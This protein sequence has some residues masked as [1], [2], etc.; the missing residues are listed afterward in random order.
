MTDQN[1]IPKLRLDFMLDTGTQ[2]SFQ[3]LCFDKISHKDAQSDKIACFK[4]FIDQGDAFP[5]FQEIFK[6][7]RKIQNTCDCYDDIEQIR[8]ICAKGGTAWQEVNAKDLADKGRFIR[9]R[10]GQYTLVNIHG[11]KLVIDGIWFAIETNTGSNQRGVII[12]HKDASRLTKDEIDKALENCDKPTPNVYLQLTPRAQPY[13]A[14]FSC[15][16]EVK[17]ED[18]SGTGE[19]CKLPFDLEIIVKEDNGIPIN[20]DLILDLGN[21]RTVALKLEHGDTGRLAD[22]NAFSAN[23][24]PLTLKN[25]LTYCYQDGARPKDDC[26][27]SSSIVLQAPPFEN[28]TAGL[29]GNASS[30]PLYLQEW[31]FSEKQK[32]LGDFLASVPNIFNDTQSKPQLQVNHRITRL[33]QMFVKLSPVLFGQD[34]EDAFNNASQFRAAQARFF[35]SSP[36]RYYWDLDPNSCGT[37]W[38]MLPNEW[39]SAS[40]LGKVPTLQCELLR[41][42][43]LNGDILDNIDVDPQHP[44]SMPVSNPKRPRYPRASSLTWMLLAL[45]ERAWEQINLNTK[46]YRQKV[47][48]NVIITFPSGWLPREKDMYRKR[49]Q[50]AVNIFAKNNFDSDTRKNINLNLEFDEA[51][52]SQMPFV[53]T[54]L[55]QSPNVGLWFDLI[56]RSRNGKNSV[57][58]MNLD[59][60]G[61]TTDYSIIKYSP[62]GRRTAGIA[63]NVDLIYKDGIA[64]AGDDLLRGIIDQ[65]ILRTISNAKLHPAIEKGILNN[66]RDGDMETDHCLERSLYVRQ[67][68]IPLALQLLARHNVGDKNLSFSPQEAGISQQQWSNFINYLCD[69]TAPKDRCFIPVTTTFAFSD[70]RI[71]QLVEELFRDIF[72]K[73]SNYAA[74]YDVD[75]LVLSGKTTE[76]PKIND[77]IQQLF[78]LTPDRII[79]TKNY[80]AG[81]WY[82]NFGEAKDT[83]LINDAKTVTAVGAA[84]LFALQQGI[85]PGWK[86]NIKNSFSTNGLT[87]QKTIWSISKKSTTRITSKQVEP[88]ISTDR[89]SENDEP[90]NITN[91][92]VIFRQSDEQSLPEPAYKF[93]VK[94]SG[95]HEL[96]KIYSVKFKATK[97]TFGSNALEIAE[98]REYAEDGQQQDSL[99]NLYQPAE[100]S[101]FQL[102][103]CPIFEQGAG[104]WQDSG[105]VIN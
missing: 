101:K 58:I 12:E 4:P 80:R 64:I 72:E 24:Q 35:Q 47:L 29:N 7:I 78:A 13:F 22:V 20:V 66:F 14:K 88:F 9:Y 23:C 1:N 85:I 52:A 99:P 82:P 38:N 27:I 75:L 45:L 92:T 73:C 46:T 43:P 49:C 71:P 86:I 51:M 56:G 104:N 74:A 69:T 18:G 8:G 98:V 44:E 91:G 84:L 60:G 65:C 100:N 21:T 28:G 50:E 15:E 79:P 42:M 53:F 39:D 90:I 2:Y 10:L 40:F 16:W 6:Q 67:I 70:E 89:D 105:L 93:I 34:A 77:L 11:D 81:K 55:S 17:D 31:S 41:F 48:K 63:L 5:K 76:I 3:P 32:S 97:D 26:I 62:D 54:E 25:K 103:I 83:N 19:R 95:D 36:K 59:I 33:P 57:H 102:T 87:N 37:Y 30:I 94:A 96:N 61:G 68:L